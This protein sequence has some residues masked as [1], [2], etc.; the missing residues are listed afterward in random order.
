MRRYLYLIMLIISIYGCGPSKKDLAIQAKRTQDSI[1]KVIELEKQKAAN[2]ERQKIADEQQK[3]EQQKW[4]EENKTFSIDE[5]VGTWNIKMTCRNSSCPGVSQGEI[6]TE[7]W[8]IN[9]LRNGIIVKVTGNNNTNSEY[10]GEFN[11]KFLTLQ[12]KSIKSGFFS[13]KTIAVVDVRLK[14]TSPTELKGT[15]EVVKEGPCKIE[16]TIIAIANK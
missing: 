13:D 16:Y 5:L 9:Y 4:E 1:D 12:S 10:K 11:G 6:T 14:M 2:D 7:T 3:L 8:N 15:R